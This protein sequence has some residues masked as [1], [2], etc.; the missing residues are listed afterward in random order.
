ME[1]THIYIYPIKSCAGISLEESMLSDRGLAFDRRWM[2]VDMNGKFLTQREIPELA[3]LRTEIKKETLIISHTLKKILP[4]ELPLQI[5]ARNMQEV[6]LWGDTFPVSMHSE[7]TNQW[8]SGVL[9]QE[10]QMVY[11]HE[12]SRRPAD[13]RYAKNN[14]I[15][16]MADGYPTLII[17]QASL[18]DLNERLVEKGE[19]AVPM[20]RFR[21]NLVFTGGDAYS[22]DTW[23]SVNIGNH[24][25]QAVKKCGRCTMTTIDQKSGQK[26][27]EPLRT[28]SSYRK[29]G[30]K[31]QFGMNLVHAHS[32]LIKV[33]DKIR[34]QSN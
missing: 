31:I 13:P 19:K 24:D 16:S 9:G 33:G 20:D 18:D 21:P 8:F 11:M 4:L 34:P 23:T 10:C 17:G 25:F 5:S 1:I 26:G 7:A 27:K 12:E 28:L 3:L 14:E 22:E 6:I 30:A 2:L 29:E 15:V 32:G